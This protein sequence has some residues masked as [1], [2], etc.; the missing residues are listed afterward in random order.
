MNQP[1]AIIANSTQNVS[2][3]DKGYIT[4]CL[5]LSFV[6][7]PT[8]AQYKEFQASGITEDYAK[9]NFRNISKTDAAK[10]LQ[11]D[12]EKNILAYGTALEGGWA[13][14]DC[15]SFKPKAPR[16]LDGKIIKYENVPI[17]QSG[18]T[19]VLHPETIK[20]DTTVVYFVEGFKKG[21]AVAQVTKARV[22][23]FTGIEQG[24][25]LVEAFNEISG[26]KR[27]ILDN[28]NSVR[29]VS[30]ANYLVKSLQGSWEIARF[31][32]NAKGI[33]DYLCKGGS[34]ADI[35]WF[36]KSEWVA[37]FQGYLKVKNGYEFSDSRFHFVNIPSD[38]RLVMIHAEKGTGKSW[39]CRQY[40]EKYSDRNLFVITHRIN[41]SRALAGDIGIPYIDDANYESGSTGLCIDSIQK[42]KLKD[43]VGAVIILD[44]I[45]QVLDHLNNSD[46]LKKKRA[47]V[48][49][50]FK[51][52]LRKVCE[53]NGL[54][55][56][57]DADY[58]AH[59]LDLM[60]ALCDV[61]EEHIFGIRNLHRF[62][63]GSIFLGGVNY[64]TQKG[65]ISKTKVPADIIKMMVKAGLSGKR[66]FACLTAQ[67]SNYL[68]STQTLEAYLIASGVPSNLIL[69]IDSETVSDASHPAFKAAEK[70]NQL[71]T[72]YP[73]ILASPSL[74]TGVDIQFKDFDYVFGI[75]NTVLSPN[76]CRQFLSRVRDWSIPRYIFTEES[77]NLSGIQV[78][79][80]EEFKK[81]VEK[82]QMLLL[83]SHPETNVLEPNVFKESVQWL[84]TNH[85]ETKRD[86]REFKKTILSGLKLE[87]FSFEA[88]DSIIEPD[89]AGVILQDLKEISQELTETYRKLVSESVITEEQAAEL[90]KKERLEKVEQ[91][92]LTNWLIQKN[93]GIEPTTEV[94]KVLTES[95]EK[96]IKAQFALLQ[97]EITKELTQK[98]RFFVSKT[99]ETAT[100]FLVSN[101]VNLKI[102]AL[103]SINFFE[104]ITEEFGKNE[105]TKILKELFLEPTN[106]NIFQLSTLKVEKEPIGAIKEIASFF[107]ITL[108][109]TRKNKGERFYKSQNAGFIVGTEDYSPTIFQHLEKVNGEKV[110]RWKEY[111]AELLLIELGLKL[112]NTLTES[113]PTL[114]F[115]YKYSQLATRSL[116]AYRLP[117]MPVVNFSSESNL[118][119]FKEWLSK[120]KTCAID[121]ETYS[122]SK[123]GGLDHINGSVRLLQL[124]DTKTVWVIERSYFT[125]IEQSVKAF[126]TN[127]HQRKVGHNIMFDLRFLRKEFG[128]IPKNC[129]DTMLG[130]RCL[131]GDMG[132]AKITSHSLEYCAL[133]YLGVTLDK[134][135]QKSD[136]G[137][138]NLS[139][140]QMTYAAMDAWVTVHLYHRLVRLTKRP[141]LL[142]LPMPKNLAWKAWE[143]E[144]RFLFAAQQ[145]E[146]TGYKID[147]IKLSEAKQQYQTLLD[148][149]QTNWSAPMLPTQKQK[150]KEYL[151]EKYSVNLKSLNKATAAEN[152]H[153]PEILLMQQI[154]ATQALLLCLTA[155]E[156]QVNLTNGY[157]KPVFKTL[158]GTGRTSSG[159]TKINKALIN[160]QSLAARVNPILKGFNLTLIK[161]L[162]LTDL[163]IDLPASHGRIS[164][165]LGNDEAALE[166]YMD[167]TKDLHCA[168]ASAVAQ[169]VFPD[170][171]YTA[172]WLQQNKKEGTAKGLRDTAKNTYYGWL[173]GAGTL[174]IQRQIKSNLQIDADKSA[175]QKALEG[176]QNVFSGTTEFA[177]KKLEELEKNKFVVNGWWC[178]F[179]EFA[180]TYL[181]WK[182]GKVGESIK[183]PA[184]KAFAGIWSRTESILMKTACYKIAERFEAENR[185]NSR[186]QNF[187]HDEINCTIGNDEAAQF[188]YETVREE[189]GKVCTRTIVGFD[190]F[191]KC[192]PLNNWSDK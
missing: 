171:N 167:D 130:S 20:L 166:A 125:L 175:C 186:L 90:F 14:Y 119:E 188:A 122:D 33:D 115:N 25:S 189:F 57:A 26:D 161:S 170:K 42:I 2:K 182:L 82:Q 71:C 139:S 168:T 140:E 70:I 84:V 18:L 6:R 99:G 132:A 65:T 116:S 35:T 146:A 50:Y 64:I 13:S 59:S 124:S 134:S 178:G 37:N 129:S 93:Y 22:L 94:Q 8:K 68:F 105:A 137:V 112:D 38:T 75:F 151:N 76:S 106:K 41:L 131:L 113:L 97:P 80:E 107:N 49:D 36:D 56:T 149:L 73:I 95:K 23:T 72:E 52:V 17:V 83:K 69:R 87:G 101:E 40:A 185:W 133:N 79:S 43:C 150:L 81:L 88:L 51:K 160:L 89:E 1:I 53:T 180:G 164:A 157:V 31:P 190:A 16:K 55:I 154:C 121:V 12:F 7:K 118:K 141:S 74:N 85:V 120:V 148:E 32:N 174:T 158:S 108:K 100:D 102:N 66:Y 173:N 39:L 159:A 165:E 98:A 103:E 21:V 184:T 61:D 126:L 34:I 136:W 109:Q 117:E 152:L 187:I 9:L 63:K 191:K 179:Y 15:R 19:E 58:D 4:P 86:K 142:L 181:C 169:A 48:Y 60:K 44:E 54:V 163:I 176:L 78:S 30:A 46:T 156:E 145:M 96:A 155:I 162:F 29:A 147:V 114:N 123:L 62:V 3:V 183:V 91:A 172:E 45:T 28:D 177:K 5:P 110:L 92:S 144:N 27:L 138:D 104:R 153:I 24:N 11:S 128:V 143:V 135:E 192:Y 127:P 10:L 67:K 77:G 111:K 47:G